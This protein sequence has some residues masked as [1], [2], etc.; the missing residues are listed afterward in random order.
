MYKLIIPTCF[1]N[2]DQRKRK[3]L[4]NKRWK[5]DSKANNFIIILYTSSNEDLNVILMATAQTI[6]VF[7]GY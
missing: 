7:C 3:E 2:R 1:V 4:L 5:E 6:I